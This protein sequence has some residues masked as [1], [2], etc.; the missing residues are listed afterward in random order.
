MN[1]TVTPPSNS[2]SL[3]CCFFLIFQNLT[4]HRDLYSSQTYFPEEPVY[5]KCKENTVW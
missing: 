3:I 1:V 4:L 5:G 2:P